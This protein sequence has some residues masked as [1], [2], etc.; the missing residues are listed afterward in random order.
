MQPN[1]TPLQRY[2]LPAYL[3]LTPLISITIPPLLPGSVELAVLLML[4]VP[5]LIGPTPFLGPHGM[6]VTPAKG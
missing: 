1:P 6:Q 4:L 2:A 3:I 5:A